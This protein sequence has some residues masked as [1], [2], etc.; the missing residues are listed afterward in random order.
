MSA[1]QGAGAGRLEAEQVRSMFDRI[2][3]IYDPLNTAM[4]AGLHHRWRERAADLAQ[5][6]PGSCVLDV[7]TG[8]GD[9]AIE[10]ARR[11]V[12][13]GEVVGSDFSEGMLARARVK[14]A[15]IHTAEPRF[16]WGDALEL[17][18]ADDS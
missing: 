4:T 6:G 14:A 9:L 2:A 17:P 16:E 12:P 7:A 11:V 10:L 1:Q 15:K 5:I 8:T 18:Y 3:R 13:G